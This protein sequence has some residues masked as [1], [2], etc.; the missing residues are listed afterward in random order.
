MQTV[1][2]DHFHDIANTLHIAIS[3]SAELLGSAA[4]SRIGNKAN[5][6]V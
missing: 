3:Q 1:V 6:A 5:F 2:H 4:C